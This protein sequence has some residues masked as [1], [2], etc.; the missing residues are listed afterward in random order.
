MHKRRISRYCVRSFVSHYGI[1]SCGNPSVFHVLRES[2]IVWDKRGGVYYLFPLKLFCLTLLNP[3]VEEPFCFLKT[4]R[5][6]TKYIHKRGMSRFFVGSSFCFSVPNFFYGNTS[7]L[8]FSR[9]SRNLKDK[10]G[11]WYHVF[12]PKMFCPTV[13]QQFAEELFC[14]SRTFRLSIK[15]VHK[16]GVRSFFFGIFYG[17]STEELHMG[18]LLCFD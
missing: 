3:C 13:P 10:R 9:V 5:L 18:N 6:S 4:F 2:K 17:N 8:F 14:A 12:P 11:G 16:K 7:V 1:F 15:K